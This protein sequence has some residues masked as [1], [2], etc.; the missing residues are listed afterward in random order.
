MRVERIHVS[1]VFVAIAIKFIPPPS[2]SLSDTIPAIS[3]ESPLSLSPKLWTLYT[4]LTAG[5]NFHISNTSF[6]KIINWWLA[7]VRPVNTC[8]E[9]LAMARPG[10]PGRNKNDKYCFVCQ[11][12]VVLCCQSSQVFSKPALSLSLSMIALK[13]NSLFSLHI[14]KLLFSV[15]Y[16]R[17]KLI[18]KVIWDCSDD[19]MRWA[20]RCKLPVCW[21]SQLKPF[22]RIWLWL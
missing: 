2:L 16:S 22:A 10:Q 3:Q 17:V 15:R 5:C 13:T 20:L 8:D 18:S 7:L 19:E 9:L 21:N 11:S 14:H 4:P 6:S 1:L 12:C